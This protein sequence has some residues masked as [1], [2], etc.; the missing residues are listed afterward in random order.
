MPTAGALQKARGWATGLLG[1]KKPPEAER[2]RIREAYRSH[3]ARL[4]ELRG[5]QSEVD[6]KLSH[7]Y[8]PQGQF[9]AL[10]G[11]Y[12]TMV[13]GMACFHIKIHCLRN[14]LVRFL[15]H[16]KAYSWLMST[17][18]QRKIGPMDIAAWYVQAIEQLLRGQKIHIAGT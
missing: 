5:H 11:R 2:Q 14:T 12:A 1:W 6:R 7:D 8:G 17:L 9:L 3:Q 13:T 10:S 16:N 18:Y 4:N 15:V